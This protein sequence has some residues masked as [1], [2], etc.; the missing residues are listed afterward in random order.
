MFYTTNTMSYTA[1]TSPKVPTT[2]IMSYATNAMHHTT[3][4]SSSKP[5][6]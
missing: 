2:D 4:S 1:N 6:P 3:T 5:D